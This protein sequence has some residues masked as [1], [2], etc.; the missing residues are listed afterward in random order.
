MAKSAKK[1]AAKPAAKSAAAK[2]PTKG[3][4]LATIAEE[5]GIS[6]KQVSGVFEALNGQIKASLKKHGAFTL[7]GLAKLVVKVKP[8]TKGGQKKKNPFTGEEMITKSKPASK[9]V[10]IRPVKALKEMA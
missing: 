2:P 6:R 5:T 3:Q 8:A 9:T 7:P 4:L 1:P 10:R